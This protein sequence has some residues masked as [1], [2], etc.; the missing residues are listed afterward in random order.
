MRVRVE[1]AILDKNCNT[2]HKQAITK[3]GILKF[4]RN[5]CNLCICL[6]DKAR[7]KIVFPKGRNA[8]IAKPI[9][10]DKDYTH[11]THMLHDI[12]YLRTH[13]QQ[14]MQNYDKPDTIPKNIVAMD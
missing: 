9:L 10:E 12:L 2:H 7:Y 5:H 6:S 3:S 1:L 11:L 14:D 4:V 8:W 13:G